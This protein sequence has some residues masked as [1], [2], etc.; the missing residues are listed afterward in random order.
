M[1]TKPDE[2][3]TYG[4][5]GFG[6]AGQLLLLELRTRGIPP[7]QIVILDE[8]FLGGALATHYGAVQSNTPWWKTRK[9]LAEYPLY[10]Q[11]VLAEGDAKFPSDQ[12]MPVRDIARL[13][14]KTALQ[15][16]NRVE[17][18]RTTVSKIE[19][20]GSYVVRHT[21]GLI[22]CQTLFVCHGGQEK[23]LDL[24]I[25]VIP[26][27]LAFDT[28]TLAQH[29]TTDDSIVLFGLSHSGVILCENLSNLGVPTT[30]IYNTPTPFEFER[31]GH[32]GGIKE[33]AIPIAEAILAGN[34]PH[35]TLQTWNDPL[36]L[37]KVLS[38]ATKC[39]YSVGFA[40]RILQGLS[41][42]YDPQTAELKNHPNAYGY[43]IAFPG[44]TVLDGKTYVDVSVLSF[45]EQIRKT[46]P[47]VLGTQ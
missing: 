3:Y 7:N 14:L 2:P 31:D 8:T 1:P 18:I 28:H 9:A 42:E 39:I 34:K 15:A 36:A 44:T 24:S 22:R 32:Y 35:I 5:L 46:L 12:C 23:S 38:K 40:P 17:K 41:T 21:F 45:Q 16:T 10:S 37:H 11:E 6:I 33:G 47:K 26:L 27:S 43:G 29:V 19:N 20:D 30:A 13:C 4:I 25:P